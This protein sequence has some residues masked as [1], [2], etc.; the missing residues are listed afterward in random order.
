[1]LCPPF[2]RLV[3][4]LSNRRITDFPLLFIAFFSVDSILPQML[5][6]DPS[7]MFVPTMVYSLPSVQCFVS[8]QATCAVESTAGMHAPKSSKLMVFILKR[9]VMGNG[10]KRLLKLVRIDEEFVDSSPGL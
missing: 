1:M 9:D 5:D 6:S 3:P 10:K 8:T 2:C 7:A 4:H